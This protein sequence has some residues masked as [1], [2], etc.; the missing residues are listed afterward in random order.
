VSARLNELLGSGS[1]ISA[2][3]RSVILVA[4]QTLRDLPSSGAL[5]DAELLEAADALES[6][7]MGDELALVSADQEVF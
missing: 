7:L 4:L 2:V 5:V 6:R 1:V 3:D